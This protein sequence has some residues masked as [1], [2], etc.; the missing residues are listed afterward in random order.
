MQH[1]YRPTQGSMFAAAFTA[2]GTTHTAASQCESALEWAKRG[3]LT[4]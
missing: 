1:M 3:L 4:S 2:K